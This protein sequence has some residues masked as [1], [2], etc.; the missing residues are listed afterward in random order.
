VERIEQLGRHPSEA[1]RARRLVASM[2]DGWDPDTVYAAKLIT[3]ELV[4]NAILHG[5]EPIDLRVECR[6]DTVRVE[7]HDAGGGGLPQRR[8]ESRDATTGRGVALVE[9]IST[10][11]DTGQGPDGST[12]IWAELERCSLAE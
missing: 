4:T 6:G 2:L 5:R 1:G 11:W 12:R 3:S 9:S 8:P 7:V 10:R